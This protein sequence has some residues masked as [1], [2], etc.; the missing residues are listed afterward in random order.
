LRATLV[1]NVERNRAASAAPDRIANG[2]F[3]QLPV[4]RMS[5]S[6]PMNRSTTAEL[7]FAIAGSLLFL[8]LSV[9]EVV[10]RGGAGTV[11]TIV[12][13]TGLS[14]RSSEDSLLLLEDASRTIPHG[15]GVAFL[16]PQDRSKDW[17]HYAVAVGLMPQQNVLYPHAIDSD[18]SIQFLIVGA[19]PF[20]DPHFVS[21]RKLPQGAIFKRK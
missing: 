6:M 21:W 11:P 16:N 9:R 17:L 12:S 18:S 2:D 10:H 13:R 4:P 19:G 20:D 8:C 5:I 7:F 1:H 3:E 15:A 14:P